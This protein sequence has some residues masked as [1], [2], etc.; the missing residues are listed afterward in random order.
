MKIEKTDNPNIV[1]IK[2]NGKTGYYYVDDYKNFKGPYSTLEDA[3][4]AFN[5]Y[6]YGVM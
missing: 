4:I 5:N 2:G 6:L 1:F 3:E